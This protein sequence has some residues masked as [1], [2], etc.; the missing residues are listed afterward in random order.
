M[1]YRITIT[2]LDTNEVNLDHTTD[3]FIVLYDKEDR[4]GAD[5]VLHAD[6]DTV[7]NLVSV[8]AAETRRITEL[9]PSAFRK[10][11]RKYIKQRLE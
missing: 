9:L 6:A 7:A 3:T 5:S 1:A 10:I 4:I 11:A 2:D 8:M